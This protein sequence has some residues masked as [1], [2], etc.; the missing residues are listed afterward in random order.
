[1]CVC[2]NISTSTMLLHEI[3]KDNRVLLA[4][5][6]CSGFNNTVVIIQVVLIFFFFLPY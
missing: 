3:M 4:I 1:M 6:I 2:A 5:S